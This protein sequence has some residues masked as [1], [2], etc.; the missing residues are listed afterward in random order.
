MMYSQARK[1]KGMNS[2]G[3]TLLELIVVVGI[4]GILA[5]VAIPTFSVWMPN[6]RLKSAAQ[7]L[8]SNMQLAKMEAIKTNGDFQIVFN[9]GAN[10]YVISNVTSGATFRTVNLSTY[11]E[12]GNI[13]FGRGNA[14]VSSPI[15]GIAYD[16]F[17][18]YST[19]ANTVVFGPRGTANEEGYVYLQNQKGTAYGIG[20]RTSGVIRLL[21]WRGSAWE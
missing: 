20:T 4:I 14:S 16:D 2:S 18:T 5:S 10:T 11:D 8:F 1:G 9:T 3:F 13:V 19:T 7:D 15:S 17:V 21:K 12:D 6:Y